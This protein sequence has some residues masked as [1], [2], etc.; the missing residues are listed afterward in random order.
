[1]DCFIDKKIHKIAHILSYGVFRNIPIYGFS[2]CSAR[3]KKQD[4]IPGMYGLETPKISNPS[5]IQHFSRISI[6]HNETSTS[7]PIDR[8]IRVGRIDDNIHVQWNEWASSTQIARV[9]YH[10]PLTQYSMRLRIVT[11]F[12]SGRHH[13]FSFP[14]HTQF[15]QTD[16]FS[17]NSKEIPLSVLG[18]FCG[19]YGGMA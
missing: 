1:M 7:K 9:V 19:S 2:F 17:S 10:T 6:S 16:T 4:R 14:S 3:H 8:F 13:H 12:R 11:L 5:M 15:I 18:T